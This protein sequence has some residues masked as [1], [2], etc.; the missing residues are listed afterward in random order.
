M[1]DPLQHFFTHPC[2]GLTS[3]GWLQQ[4]HPIK[5]TAIK[6][7]GQRHFPSK[8]PGLREQI[9]KKEGYLEWVVGE[10]GGLAMTL[11][12]PKQEPVLLIHAFHFFPQKLWPI[13]IYKY[14][15]QDGMSLYGSEQ[16]SWWATADTLSI[17]SEPSLASF[18]LWAVLCLMSWNCDSLF[19]EMPSA[20]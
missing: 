19:G 2:P 3:S 17:P 8:P 6:T 4:P 9:I 10:D 13:M 15:W 7:E 11:A 1:G 16:C 5:S 18:S 12:T 14:P 20:S